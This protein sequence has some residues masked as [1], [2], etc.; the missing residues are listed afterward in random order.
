[1][2]WKKIRK[3]L[4]Y[5]LGVLMSPIIFLVFLL[6]RIILALFPWVRI[7]TIRDWSI[8]DKEIAYSFVRVLMFIL[9]GLLINWLFF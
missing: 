8:N 7:T 3:L 5:G 4:Y 1:M 2:N 6:D 9:M